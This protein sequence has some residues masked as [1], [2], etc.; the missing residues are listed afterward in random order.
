MHNTNCSVLGVIPLRRAYTLYRM[1]TDAK[2]L[3]R[4][5]AQN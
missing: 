2:R 1:V 4:G 3:V 5:R